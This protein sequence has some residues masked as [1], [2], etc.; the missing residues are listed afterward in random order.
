VTKTTA[1]PKCSRPYCSASPTTRIVS[2][3][4]GPVDFCG[5]CAGQEL[6][7]L[8]GWLAWIQAHPEQ[9]WGPLID[10]ALHGAP[11]PPPTA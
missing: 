9:A 2:S 3:Q 7:R 1:A 8:A 10:Q 6:A 4:D 11:V 5:M